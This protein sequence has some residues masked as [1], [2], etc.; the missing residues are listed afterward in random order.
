MRRM[1]RRTLLKSPPRLVN[2][3]SWLRSSALCRCRH[4]QVP[5]RVETRLGCHVSR[6]LDWAAASAHNCR[7]G[8]RPVPRT[9]SS[10]DLANASGGQA[11]SCLFDHRWPATVLMACSSSAPDSAGGARRGP[12]NHRTLNR[13]R[14]NLPLQ[15]LLRNRDGYSAR[16]DQPYRQPALSHVSAC[17]SSGGRSSSSSSGLPATT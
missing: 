15:T 1:G 7:S 8:K 16:G 9:G 5:R 10:H 12:T 17:R 13:N 3:S 2:I 6:R 4:G 14:H 11:R